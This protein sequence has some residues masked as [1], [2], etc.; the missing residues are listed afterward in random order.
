ML[1][2]I[3]VIVPVYNVEDYLPKCIESVRNQ[4]FKNLE[5]LLINDGSTDCCG[6]IC[7]Q[8]AAIDK[9]IKVIHKANSGLSDARNMGIEAATGHFLGFVDSDDW[10]DEDMYEVLY[11]LISE[12][13][14]DIAICRIREISSKGV[15]DESTDNLVV[16]DGANAIKFLVTKKNN[17]KF[18]HGITNK[19][20]R[21]EL[22][23]NFRF[24]VGMYIEDLYFTPPL[25]YA[26]KRCVYKDVAKYNYLIDRENSIMNSKV[27]EK[28]IFDELSGYQELEYFLFHK[29]LYD[30]IAPI[31]E[32]LLIRLLYFHYEVK[33]SSLENK[34]KLLTALEEM[35]RM[36]FNKS[37]KNLLNSKRQLQITLFEWSPELYNQI[38]ENVNKMKAFKNKINLKNKL[39]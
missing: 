33:H 18:E 6:A 20:I 32:M 30:Y 3:S 22:I 1:P 36:N 38:K 4:T 17:Y 27:T 13:E 37:S 28:R 12:Y 21:K 16:C 39:L 35:F 14:A 26:S 29:G 7:E 8:Y 34:E 10:I 11:H 19:L 15:V 9:R 25:M 31:H 24:P 23:E 5:I 2:K